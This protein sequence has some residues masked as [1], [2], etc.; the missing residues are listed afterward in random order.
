MKN[1]V[2][3]RCSKF[4]FIIIELIERLGSCLLIIGSCEAH[5]NVINYRKTVIILSLIIHDFVP[6]SGT[7]HH[8]I[9]SLL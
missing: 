5:A 2:N 4:D 9:V 3:V 6:L 7:L 1:W 8:I